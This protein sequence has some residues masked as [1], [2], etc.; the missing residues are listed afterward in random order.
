MVG[1]THTLRFSRKRILRSQQSLKDFI[2]DLKHDCDRNSC[3]SE[4]LTSYC[5]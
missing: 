3:L 1:G 5:I 2:M 4:I